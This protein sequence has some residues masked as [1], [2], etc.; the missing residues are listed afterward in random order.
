MIV[1]VKKTAP[2]ASEDVDVHRKHVEEFLTREEHKQPKAP[3]PKSD[4][5]NP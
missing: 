1:A 3:L 2:K 5:A 4:R